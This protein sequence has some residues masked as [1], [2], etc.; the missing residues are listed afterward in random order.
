[1]NARPC[2]MFHG[3]LFEYDTNYIKMKNLLLGTIYRK[4]GFFLI[5]FF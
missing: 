5:E 1:M 2:V 3:D 4:N